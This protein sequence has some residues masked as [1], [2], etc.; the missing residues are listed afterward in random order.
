MGERILCCESMSSVAAVVVLVA[1][2]DSL[3]RDLETLP[4]LAEAV[5]AFA[6]QADV[7]HDRGGSCEGPTR[8]T[9]PLVANDI[10]S[11][12]ARE[13]D[14]RLL[15]EVVIFREVLRL[16]LDLAHPLR[17]VVVHMLVAF[18]RVEIAG[19]VHL[20]EPERLFGARVDAVHI[21]DLADVHVQEDGRVEPLLLLL[22][23]L[24]LAADA[25]RR[26][27]AARRLEGAA[28]TVHRR[29]ALSVCDLGMEADLD[30]IDHHQ[31]RR[32]HRDI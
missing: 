10:A 4:F 13:T 12:L 24:L 32:Q 20:E 27:L 11:L 6:L 2:D 21:I 8:P 19:G 26:R 15:A 16:D 1:C 17:D 7:R 29:F 28:D 18:Q 9:L 25:L 22:R 5:A 3:D 14:G 23:R 30:A 31:V